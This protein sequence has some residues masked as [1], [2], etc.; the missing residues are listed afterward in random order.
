MKNVATFV[1]TYRTLKRN[2]PRRNWKG[3]KHQIGFSNDFSSLNN[4]LPPRARWVMSSGWSGGSGL[5]VSHRLDCSSLGR[6]QARHVLGWF[7]KWRR[8]GRSLGFYESV[9]FT[10]QYPSDMH[11][12]HAKWIMQVLRRLLTRVICWIASH[13]AFCWFL[14]TAPTYK[15]M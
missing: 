9:S 1:F 6:S 7:R 13:Q 2:N 10:H 4:I 5:A 8:V 14:A 11:F 12:L 15:K 3:W